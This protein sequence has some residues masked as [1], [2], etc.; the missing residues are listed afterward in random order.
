MRAPFARGHIEF[1]LVGED[2]HADLVIVLDCCEGEDGRGFGRNLILGFGSRAKTARGG[3]VHQKHDQHLALFPEFLDEGRAGTGRDVPVDQADIVTRLVLAHFLELDP[4]PFEDRMVLPPEEMIDQTAGPDLDAA[5]LGD[6][7]FGE[8]NRTSA[9]SL[10]DTSGKNGNE[11]GFHG[12]ST[13]SKIF[14]TICSEVTC[15]ASAS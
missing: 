13:W 14:W 11:W 10:R 9:A 12:T 3:Q 4:L 2:D 6:E 1:D 15:S 8:H 5:D 7:F